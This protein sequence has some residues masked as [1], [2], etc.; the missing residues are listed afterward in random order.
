V[1]TLPAVM[2]NHDSALAVPW[3]VFTCFARRGA[4]WRHGTT[5]GSVHRCEPGLTSESY[6]HE[7]YF[8]CIVRYFGDQR[9]VPGP[10]LAL[11]SWRRGGMNKGNKEAVPL[12]TAPRKSVYNGHSC[13]WSLLYFFLSGV[14]IPCLG[15]EGSYGIKLLVNQAL[16][17][18]A[19]DLVD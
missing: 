10:S 14:G 2:V 6:E 8:R 13:T 16:W 15:R 17:T 19:S 11:L 4:T 7:L 9:V 18:R 5:H 1:S 3:S 12:W